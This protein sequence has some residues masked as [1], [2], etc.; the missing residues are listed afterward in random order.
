MPRHHF[1]KHR[2]HFRELRD[3]RHDAGALRPKHGYGFI[4]LRLPTSRY[5][6]R[7]A[8]LHKLLSDAKANTLT[9]A[10]DDGNFTFQ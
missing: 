8:M 3:V 1:P 9:T 5:H 2:L 10:S 4:E 6:D 7:G